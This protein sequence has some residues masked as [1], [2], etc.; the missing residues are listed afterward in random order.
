MVVGN[1]NGK[2]SQAID[3]YQKE[4]VKHGRMGRR[5]TDEIQKMSPST[6]QRCSRHAAAVLSNKGV[7]VGT[8]DQ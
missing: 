8:A 3:K 5:F 7:G 4:V 1:S 6:T 2:R